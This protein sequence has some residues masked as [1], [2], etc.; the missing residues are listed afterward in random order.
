MRV[1]AVAHLPAGVAPSD[2]DPELLRRLF[3][4]RQRF[5]PDGTPAHPVNLPGSSPLREAF[6]RAVFGQSVRDL[7]PYWNDRYF[8]G[9][10]PPPTVGSEAAVLLFLERT[11]GGIGYVQEPAT[12]ELDASLTR[13]ICLPPSVPR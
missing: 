3:L 13:L 5:W 1:C 2:V 4:I 12:A 9:T 8:H 7:A 11:P 10:S 6:S